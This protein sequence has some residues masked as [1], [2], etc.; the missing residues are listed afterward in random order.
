MK[1]KGKRFTPAM[2]VAMVALGVALSGTAVAGTA[3]LI[4]S[5]QIKDGS[6]T[7]SDIN[8]NARHAL[9]GKPGDKGEK[10]DKGEDAAEEYGVATVR[11]Q[12]GATAPQSVWATYSTGSVRRSATPRAAASASRA[13]RRRSRAR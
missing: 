3:K 11:V 7:L 9:K 10:G 12:R 8:A 13:P 5:S 4:T 1:L 2:I 6:I